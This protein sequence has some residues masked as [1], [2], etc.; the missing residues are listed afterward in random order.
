MPKTPTHYTRAEAEQKLRELSNDEI[1]KA[2]FYS[3]QVAALSR[4]AY[5]PRDLM[6]EACVR[7]LDGSRR[8]KRSLRGPEH[9]FGV[10][11]SVQNSWLK[12]DKRAGVG[13]KRLVDSV[14]SNEEAVVAEWPLEQMVELHE[15]AE[16]L[17]ASRKLDLVEKC[18]LSGFIEG[19]DPKTILE[20]CRIT[21]DRYSDTLLSLSIKLGNYTGG[22]S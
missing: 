14:E 6:N 7:T 5:D 8:W 3:E 4:G 15:R 17:L 16:S 22:K 18:V 10:M 12:R 13:H 9:L 19:L 1:D 20:S 11:R 21:A 2:T